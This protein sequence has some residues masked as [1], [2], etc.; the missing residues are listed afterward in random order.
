MASK[1]GPLR[2]GELREDGFRFVAYRKRN[3][4]SEERYE[5]WASPEAWENRMNNCKD[6]EK[7]RIPRLREENP[8]Q[9]DRRQ[10]N[11]LASNAK[12]RRRD[13]PHGL[14]MKA[15]I[16]AT[17]KGLEFNIEKS[18]ILVPEFCPVFGMKLVL[19]DGRPHDASPSL[20]RIDN[21]KG[22]IKGNIVVVSHKAN[23]LKRDATIAQLKQVVAFYESL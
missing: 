5:L 19:G 6:V 22:Y 16:R 21:T 8:E 13:I 3:K 18:D 7:R 23:L 10:A 1:Y 14:W 9:L 20:D 15:K 2:Y 4:N 17:A 12:L 11:T